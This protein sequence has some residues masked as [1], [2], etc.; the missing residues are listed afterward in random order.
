MAIRVEKCF[1]LRLR[2]RSLEKSLLAAP[3]SP[4]PS[5]ANPETEPMQLGGLRISEAER[6]PRIT[7]RLCMYCGA[8][9][10][11]CA[12]CSVKARARQ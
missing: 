12:A 3:A 8:A 9:C 6:Q 7:G 4:P 2:A 1:E 10:H 11:F 5:A